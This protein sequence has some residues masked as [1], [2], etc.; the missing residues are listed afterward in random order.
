MITTQP[1]SNERGLDSIEPKPA[2]R[3]AWQVQRGGHQAD[4]GMS[5]QPQQ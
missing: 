3:N 5:A 1:G 2:E 4:C